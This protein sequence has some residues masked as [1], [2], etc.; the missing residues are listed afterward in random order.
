MRIE[1]NR[2]NNLKSI[3]QSSRLIHLLNHFL[4]A[5]LLCYEIVFRRTRHGKFLSLR[6]SLSQVRSSSSSESS[7]NLFDQDYIS[8]YLMNLFTRL[9][10]LIQAHVKSTY[11]IQRE[12]RLLKR[13]RKTNHRCI[14]FT[15]IKS[16]LNMVGWKQTNTTWTIHLLTAC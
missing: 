12:K 9:V 11:L 14:Q 6:R 5:I 2:Q 1:R 15:K 16:S 8:P 13:D 10:H 3:R 4:S 7:R